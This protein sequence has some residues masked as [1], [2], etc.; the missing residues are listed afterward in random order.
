MSTKEE[1][2]VLPPF[3]IKPPI[4][5]DFGTSRPMGLFFSIDNKNVTLFDVLMTSESQ[6][7]VFT[8][9]S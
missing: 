2:L 7:M 8:D 5:Y 4:Y 6:N 3:A 9:F 1:W